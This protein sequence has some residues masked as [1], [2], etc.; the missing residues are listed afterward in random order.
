MY[1]VTTAVTASA[2][3]PM[4]SA[5]NRD[6]TISRMS[7]AH[8]DKRKQAGT[9]I[10]VGAVGRDPFMSGLSWEWRV[11]IGDDGRRSA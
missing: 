7:P 1:A 2:L 11:S 5:S 8:P 4:W 9:R 3:P 6:Q 10:E